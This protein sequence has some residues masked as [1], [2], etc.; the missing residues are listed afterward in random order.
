MRGLGAPL[1]S[2]CMWSGTSFIAKC[3]EM[4][5]DGDYLG[6]KW[7]LEDKPKLKDMNPMINLPYI[8]DGD[9]VITQTNACMSHLGRKLGLWGTSTVEISQCE[10]LLCEIYDLRS[11]MT[12]MA[13]D[14]NFETEAARK[15]VN[16]QKK[17]S[18]LSK[19]EAWLELNPLFSESTPFLVGGHA[20]AP[21]FHLFEILDQYNLLSVKVLGEDLFDILPK[22]KV[23]Y[24]AWVHPRMQPYLKSKLHALPFNN[25]GASFGS[26]PQRGE[27]RCWGKCFA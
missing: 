23:F 5:A 22:C 20:T 11:D 18:N 8:I 19:L 25:L 15:V 16:R 2:M 14:K 7:F 26:A 1:R 12:R 27:V 21:D 24:E 4:P 13:Y 17:K 10:Q 3:H 6:A 9:M